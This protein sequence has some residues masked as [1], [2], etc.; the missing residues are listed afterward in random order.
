[1]S[2]YDNHKVDVLTNLGKAAWDS[3]EARRQ[4]G[5]KLSLALWTPFAA[6]IGAVIT[7]KGNAQAIPTNAVTVILVFVFSV[8][9]FVLYYWFLKGMSSAQERDK[10]IAFYY[11]DRVMEIIREEFPKNIREEIKGHTHKAEGRGVTGDWCLSFQLAVTGLLG[12]G[13]T[14]ATWSTMK[15]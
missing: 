8:M 6:F 15:P 2:E 3:F 10:K 11:R 9:I 14:F 5:W 7:G 13:A 4:I 1:M 12:V